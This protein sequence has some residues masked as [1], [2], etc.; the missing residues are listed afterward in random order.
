MPEALRATHTGH[1][2]SAEQGGGGSV[3]VNRDTVDIWETLRAVPGVDGMA[4]IV[5]HDGQHLLTDQ[6]D[7]VD[8]SGTC[9][10]AAT[11]RWVVSH[12]GDRIAF[13]TL[14][15]RFMSA[16]DG[17]GRDIELKRVPGDEPHA[18][19]W[20]RRYDLDRER[21]PV[22]GT[23]GPGNGLDH[24]ERRLSLAF[25]YPEID[26]LAAC[27]I[28]G[29]SDAWL[30]EHL[31]RPEVTEANAVKVTANQGHRPAINAVPFDGWRNLDTL[32]RK[33]QIII[34]A[35][36]APIVMLTAQ[37]YWEQ[38]LHKD[39]GALNRCLEET[40]RGIA[41]L[42]LL[43]AGMWEVGEVFT[44][45]HLEQRHLMNQLIRRGAVAA[46]HPELRIGVHE[47]VLEGVPASDL[48][49]VGPCACLLQ[50]GF[51]T[52]LYRHVV[53]PGG[54]PYEGAVGFM[55]DNVRRIHERPQMED[56]IV[57]AD[58]HSIP[59]RGWGATQTL[60]DARVRGRALVVEG[61]AASDYNGLYRRAA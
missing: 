6:G 37:T 33:L 21:P 19:E 24:D 38:E 58:E 23:P 9:L 14:D 1:Y 15:G 34:D 16:R 53:G 7:H 55:Q 4:A 56:C 11:A 51:R 42:C 45:R 13:R 2:V 61:Q 30:H 32:R 3:Q 40:T 26:F 25:L 54:H 20:W 22:N 41:D 17:G 43:A 12:D 48:A 44:R 29:E 27:R 36:K 8:A 39:I 5:T 28:G 10:D 18:Y 47:R 57:I 49:H 52:H 59:V 50:V 46:G 35:G 60:D 31:A